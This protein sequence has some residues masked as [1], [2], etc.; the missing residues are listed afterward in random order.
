MPQLTPL[1]TFSTSKP[2]IEVANPLKP[3]KYRFRLTVVDSARNESAPAEIVVTVVD[4]RTDPRLPTDIL[5]DRVLRD[6]IVL[7]PIGGGIFR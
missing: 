1:R 4:P 2:Q 3:G 6:R 5:T 7:D